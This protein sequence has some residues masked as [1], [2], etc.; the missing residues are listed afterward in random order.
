MSR[1]VF[2]LQLITKVCDTG[3][4]PGIQQTTELSGGLIIL[5]SNNIHTYIYMKPIRYLINIVTTIYHPKHIYMQRPTRIQHCLLQLSALWPF[6]QNPDTDGSHAYEHHYG[7]VVHCHYYYKFLIFTV[8]KTTS[9]H[10]FKFTYRNNNTLT[11]IISQEVPF[12]YKE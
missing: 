3:T 1:N 9:W 5:T 12:M 6:S 10:C 11:T 4:C 2:Q 8:Q 7:E